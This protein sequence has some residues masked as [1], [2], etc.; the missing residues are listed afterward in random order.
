MARY[1][2]GYKKKGAETS[3]VVPIVSEWSVAIA[4]ARARIIAEGGT[5]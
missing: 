5:N 2:E 3:Q 1:S 4:V